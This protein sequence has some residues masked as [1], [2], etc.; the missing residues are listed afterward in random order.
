MSEALFDIG[1]FRVGDRVWAFH[2]ATLG[3]LHWATVTKVGR[4]WLHVDWHVGGTG[5]VPARDVIRRELVS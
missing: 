1:D 4:K 3:C 5:R 2:P